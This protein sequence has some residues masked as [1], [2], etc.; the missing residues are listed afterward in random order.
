MICKQASREVME[1]CPDRAVYRL[2]QQTVF[3]DLTAS[4]DSLWDQIDKERKQAITRGERQSFGLLRNTLAFDA[5]YTFISDFCTARHIV[6]PCRDY[7]HCIVQQSDTWVVTLADEPVFIDV[8]M[9][10]HPSRVRLMYRCHNV[11]ADLSKTKRGYANSFLGWHEML[12]YQAQGYRI[13][14]W[15][16]IFTN[17][18]SPHYGITLFK[19]SYGGEVTEE[20]DMLLAGKL[21]RSCYYVGKCFIARDELAVDEE[22]LAQV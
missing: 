18:D 19:R 9:K 2:P 12:H 21:A 20:W 7:L 17:P 10:D 8:V 5:L 14:D 11:H 15:G 3:N 22:Q 4:A 13:F 16:G 6:K 1:C